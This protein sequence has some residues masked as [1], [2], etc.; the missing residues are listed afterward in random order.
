MIPLDIGFVRSEFTEPVCWL[1]A[2]PLSYAESFWIVYF[3]SRILQTGFLNQTHEFSKFFKGDFRG[4]KHIATFFED[5]DKIFTRYNFQFPFCLWRISSR[6]ISDKIVF[7]SPRL[8]SF[9]FDS[10]SS[11]QRDNNTTDSD[12]R[13]NEKL[14]PLLF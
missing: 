9:T 11:T 7:R 4:P 13:H 12:T 1:L 2:G 5:F 3:L 10:A 14:A 8:K 6:S